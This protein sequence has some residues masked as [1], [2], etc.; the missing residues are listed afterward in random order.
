MKK[1]KI[2][3]VGGNALSDKELMDFHKKVL[4]D[5]LHEY[6]AA[7]PDT[8]VELISCILPPHVAIALGQGLDTTVHE[9]LSS[10]PNHTYAMSDCESITQFVSEIRDVKQAVLD[11]VDYVWCLGHEMSATMCRHIRFVSRG[12]IVPLTEYMEFPAE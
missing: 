6:K 11:E 2:Q 9:V 12:K 4:I 8:D 5:A 3:L 10:V 1:V 7:N